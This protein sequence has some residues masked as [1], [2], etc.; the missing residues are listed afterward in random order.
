MNEKI[1]IQ[2]TAS[3][4]RQDLMR[5]L[6]ELSDEALKYVWLPVL[7][8]YLYTD[9]RDP[10]VLSDEDFNRFCLIAAGINRPYETVQKLVNWDTYYFRREMQ[11][12]GE[13]S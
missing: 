1:Q 3:D 12:A 8:A 7:G 5:M 6:S 2:Y 4:V 11:K 10:D 9:Q 13:Q